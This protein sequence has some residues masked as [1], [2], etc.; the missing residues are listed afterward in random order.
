MG[1]MLIRNIPDA[2]KSRLAERAQARAVAAC[3]A[4]AIDLLRKSL[5]GREEQPERHSTS[6]WD[7]ICSAIRR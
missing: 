3:P 1:D 6:A 7:A 4:K 5:A 2:L